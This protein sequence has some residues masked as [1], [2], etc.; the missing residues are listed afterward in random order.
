MQDLYSKLEK[1]FID[2]SNLKSKIKDVV[3]KA[4]LSIQS[5]LIQNFKHVGIHFKSK[6]HDDDLHQMSDMCFNLLEF[7]LLVD[8][9]LNPWIVSVKLP[10]VKS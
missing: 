8:Q 4:L 1:V 10:R 7:N 9:Q 2:V 3:I 6:Y 5:D